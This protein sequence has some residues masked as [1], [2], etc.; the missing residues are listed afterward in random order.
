MVKMSQPSKTATV[1]QVERSLKRLGCV[2]TIR[3]TDPVA[4]AARRMHDNDVGCLVVLDGQGKVAGVVS[5]RDVIKKVVAQSVNPAK[6]TVADIMNPSVI[7]CRMDTLIG[8]ANRIM[9]GHGI[10]HLPIIEDGVPLGMLSSRD[11][12]AYHLSRTKAIARRQSAI[13]ETIEKEHPEI[14][15]WRR[16]PT[17][18]IIID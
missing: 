8:Q 12:L 15:R 16:D 5:E 9:T 10:R 7:S 3:E 18:R 11:I 14:A 17:G 6:V 2:I 13:L 4:A 1:R